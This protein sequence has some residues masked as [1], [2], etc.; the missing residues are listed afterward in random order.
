MKK[1]Y[2]NII[3]AAFFLGVAISPAQALMFSGRNWTD[4][5]NDA[6]CKSFAAVKPGWA[7]IFTSKPWA[8]T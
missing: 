1:I 8:A 6:G 4:Y 3:L 7:M 5:D 2:F